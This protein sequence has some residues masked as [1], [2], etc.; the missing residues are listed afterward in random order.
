MINPEE[1]VM[2]GKLN[3]VEVTAQTLESNKPLFIS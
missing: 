1:D 2:T 3:V